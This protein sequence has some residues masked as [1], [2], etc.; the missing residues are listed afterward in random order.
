MTE[1][2]YRHRFTHFTDAL[3]PVY[4]LAGVWHNCRQYSK[5][6]SLWGRREEVPVR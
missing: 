2:A 5:S 3:I 6:P 1:S 4:K